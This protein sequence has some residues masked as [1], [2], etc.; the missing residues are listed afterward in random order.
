M[1]LKPLSDEA[2]AD[3]VRPLAD[4]A[5]LCVGDCRV[6]TSIS[7][8]CTAAPACDGIGRQ[9]ASAN[10]PLFH[11]ALRNPSSPDP[12]SSLDRAS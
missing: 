4:D 9:S 1:R 8:N 3:V 12:Q 11:S 10:L 5:A 6:G 7:A 2:D